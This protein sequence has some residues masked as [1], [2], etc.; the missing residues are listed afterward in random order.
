MNTAMPT[1]PHL[2]AEHS[3]G[4]TRFATVGAAV[5]GLDRLQQ[6]AA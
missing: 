6:S 2:A 3:T 4:I 1:D 5:A